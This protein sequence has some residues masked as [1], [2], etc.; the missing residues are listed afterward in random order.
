MAVSQAP[1]IS[2]RRVFCVDGR[3]RKLRPLF[4]SFFLERLFTRRHIASGRH[5]AAFRLQ[6]RLILSAT[7]VAR[8]CSGPV[9]P[10]QFNS[11]LIGTTPHRG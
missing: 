6:S 3:E 9:L 10:G 5:L 11:G 7:A 8:R 4:W 1:R 2:S